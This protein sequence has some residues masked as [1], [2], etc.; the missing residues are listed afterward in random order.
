MTAARRSAHC[1]KRTHSR[2]VLCLTTPK[3]ADSGDGARTSCLGTYWRTTQSVAVRL[4]FATMCREGWP[5][6]EMPKRD[7]YLEA[8][9]PNLQIHD[10]SAHF[11][12]QCFDEIHRTMVFDTMSA[13]M[14]CSEPLQREPLL[15][16][17]Q[18]QPVV[19]GK[20]G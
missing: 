20:I 16:R 12:Q 15:Y 6:L 14:V 9:K 10:R 19:L 2:C 18:P 8:E 11:R 5:I 4:Q 13:S 7:S 1:Q 3:D 17:A